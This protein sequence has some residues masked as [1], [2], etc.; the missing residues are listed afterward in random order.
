MF[1]MIMVMSGSCVCLKSS[2]KFSLKFVG[3][4]E[5]NIGE[6]KIYNL[7]LIFIDFDNE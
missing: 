7:D 3:T 2:L 1:I 4:A 6:N 5:I